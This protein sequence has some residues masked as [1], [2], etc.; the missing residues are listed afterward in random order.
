MCMCARAHTTKCMYASMYTHVSVCYLVFKEGLIFNIYI[1]L[2][3][4]VVDFALV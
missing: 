2:N 3:G 4:L 1:I